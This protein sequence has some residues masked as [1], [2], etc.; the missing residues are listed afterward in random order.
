MNNFTK[1][2]LTL[3]LLMGMGQ[4]IHAQ[5]I[6]YAA[7]LRGAQETQPRLTNGEGLLVFVLNLSDSTMEVFGDF[8]NLSSPVDTSIAGGLHVHNGLAGQNGGIELILTPQLDSDFLGGSV[9]EEFQLTAAQIET[10]NDRGF[11]VNLHTLN[12]GSGELRGQIQEGDTNRLEVDFLFSANLY[13]SNE[14]HN[15]MSDARGAVVLDLIGD[16]LRVSGSFSNLAG[17]LATDIVGGAHIHLGY[18]G[19]NGG[20]ELVLNSELD[21]DSLGGVFLADSNVFVL[22]ATQI[23]QL[24]NQELYVNIHS[25]AFRAGELRGQIVSQPKAVFRSFLGG[26]QEVPS[27]LSA[28]QGQVIAAWDSDDNGDNILQVSGSFAGLGSP[29]N[30]N[31]GA[32]LHRGYAGQNGGVEVA[33]TPVLSSGDSSGIFATDANTFLT[34]PAIEGL[35][36]GRE[37]YV[38]IHSTNVPSGE[39]RGQVLPEG[40]FFLYQLLSGTQEVDP[41]FTT[42]NG[43][44]YFEVRGDELV[45]T[46]SF[47]GLNSGFNEAIAGGAHL[48]S[49]S[50]GQ[51]GGIRY[52]LSTELNAAQDTGFFRADSNTFATN[53][54]ITD[55]LRQRGLYTNIH[56]DDIPSGELRGQ[57]LG[58]GQNYFFAP[59]SGAS[60]VPP[61]N[62]TG[63]GNIAL[64]WRNGSVLASGSINDLATPFD[65]NIAGGSHIHNGLAGQNGGIAF[66]LTPS[67]AGDSLSGNFFPSANQNDFS[68]GATDTLLSRGLYVNIHTKGSPSGE[69]RGQILPP[70]QAYFTTSLA[71]K[72]EATPVIS[73]GLGGLKGEWTNGELVLSGAFSDLDSDFDP[74]VAGGA[75]IH[76]GAAGMNGGIEL[77]LTTA[78]DN[79]L[80]GGAFTADSN[81]FTISDTLSGRI[82]SDSLY[83]NIHSVDNPSGELRGQILLETNEFPAPAP[84]ITAPP[85]GT[86]LTIEGDSATAFTATWSR[87]EDADGNKV[88][89][90]WELAATTDFAAPLVFTNTGT[91]SSFTTDFAT[92]DAL[93]SG[94]GLNVGDS[95]TLYHRASSLDGAVCTVGATDSVVLTRGTLLNIGSINVAEL[96]VYPS[97]TRDILN[98]R[99]KE[100]RAQSLQIRIIDVSGKVVLSQGLNVQA[101]RVDERLQVGQVA[102]GIYQLV[103]Q[104]ERGQLFT[105]KFVKE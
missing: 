71:G 45:Y 59:L 44:G 66:F 105:T 4:Y 46:G 6:A 68:A 65:P 42:A 95:V 26:A 57:L 96:S 30:T 103:I 60:E 38:N 80:R 77:F 51:N 24:R 101:N 23:T 79:D 53:P 70:A 28:G 72:N 83:V 69:L 9:D 75:H 14:V 87:S 74:N 104:D 85:S 13:G 63:F 36:A 29:F 17:P 5:E 86:R 56:T 91:D 73:S 34:T 89:Y 49:G 3:L 35:I 37:L 25:Q 100:V 92:V 15:V 47:Q 93:L 67:L 20:I 18:A 81:T 40:N 55:T 88:I 27:V 97:P 102:A 19:Q 16:T 21:S 62:S 64:E 11:Y 98:I 90:T 7:K 94:A 84:G 10:F 78:L 50:A 1:W 58:E 32:H 43:A 76:L 41:V 54:G 22:T 52:L 99:M 31:I 12:F 48:H 33:L 2:A 8:E 61:V 82:S 39:L